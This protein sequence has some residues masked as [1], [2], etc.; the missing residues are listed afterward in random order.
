MRRIASLKC[1]HIEDKLSLRA[2]LD[3][4]GYT[5]F[6]FDGA[7][8]FD[9]ESFFV[10]AAIDFPE[11]TDLVA[12]KSWEALGDNILSRTVSRGSEKYV[13]VW[14]YPEH[15]YENDLEAFLLAF[16]AIYGY[17]FDR[18]KRKDFVRDL[19]VLF[20]GEGQGFRSLQEYLSRH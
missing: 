4:D 15:L 7:N 18:A 12:S 2:L 3:S 19:T 20:L 11:T 1:F 10:Q 13:V 17:I 6:E 9:A 5:T 14:C 8:V 16:A